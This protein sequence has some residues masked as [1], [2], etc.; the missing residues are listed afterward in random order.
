MANNITTTT[1]TEATEDSN[2]INLDEMFLENTEDTEKLL[3]KSN[4]AGHV[5]KM[6]TIAKEDRR[7]T[8]DIWLKAFRDI[9]GEY[10]SKQKALISQLQVTN[11]Q[12]SEAFLKVAKTK[13]QAAYGQ[14]L[15]VISADNRFPIGVEPTP[16]PD[17]TAN[18]AHL[19]TDN[20][21]EAQE[22][23]EKL[24]KDAVVAGDVIGFAGDGQE[25]P[26]GA[27]EQS[28]L[29]GLRDK[30]GAFLGNKVPVEGPATDPSQIEFHP[31][32]EAAA[33]M[34][35]KM[36]D[37]LSEQKAEDDLKRS[38]WELI[39]LGT[40]IMKGPMT[41]NKIVHKWVK[42]D[43]TGK[44]E[45]KPITKLFPEF[46]SP[47]IWN[48]YPDPR[49][50]SVD[51]AEFI[52]ERHLVG[53][54]EL[55]KWKN[56][57]G[58]DKE[59]I[60]RM[61]LID[62]QYDEEHWERDLVDNNITQKTNK[63]DI[64]EYWG[65]IDEGL[66]RGL[67]L[68]FN[69]NQHLQIVAFVWKHEI[70]KVAVNPFLPQRI[71]YHIVPYEELAYQIWGVGLPENMNDSTDLMN[72]HWRGAIDN[73]NLAGNVMLEVDHRNL[74]VGQDFKIRPGKIWKKANGPPGQS[75]Y[76]ISFKDTSQSHLVA[77][78]KARQLADE[79]TG[80]L[81]FGQGS[82]QLPSSVR[83]SGQTS[84]LLQGSALTIKTAIKN[85]DRYLLEPLGEALFQW[86]MQFDSEDVEI[87]GDF[88]I[89]AKGTA[90]LLQREVK[91]Q[92]LLTFAQ[93]AGT[94]PIMAPLV[95]FEYIMK[96]LAK[97]L[98]LD[99]DNVIND[100]SKAK[101]IAELM[102]ISQGGAQQQQQQIPT[103][104]TGVGGQIAE[105][106]SIPQPTETVSASP[107]Q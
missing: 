45:Y 18:I 19:V 87:R 13:S 78:D 77:F 49:A 101:L 53:R 4:L 82:A 62:P 61:L 6:W 91:S 33:K 40:G 89:I 9:R 27:T 15:E 46:S 2:P 94:N 103:E 69:Q 21:I 74:Q 43:E 5:Q 90:S 48:V 79:A 64:K 93:V 22:Q 83:T 65:F 36:L 30:I 55:R 24:L 54:A 58:F 81:S 31:A 35:R 25:L 56:I 14:V 95:D 8:E 44:I 106:G 86:N 17:G 47:S 10:S 72:A 66:A 51:D 59:A 97:S 107:E 104:Q 76:P 102:Q 71:P 105:V 39:Y 11:P 73:L 75:I 29:G 50:V 70:L 28:L 92:R 32:K 60:D 41:V 7:N 26:P 68:K 63:Y 100:P 67:G 23:E 3:A 38:V 42:N 84:M 37:Q 1:A 98:D 12:S 80:I 99:P 52:V 34:E 20:N 16:I 57:P 88:E 85:L 96:E